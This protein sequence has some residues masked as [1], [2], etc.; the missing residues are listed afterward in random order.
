MPLYQNPYG[1]AAPRSAVSV[2]VPW[3]PFQEGVGYPV[4]NG[5]TGGT[6]DVFVET[7]QLDFTGQV[8]TPTMDYLPSGKAGDPNP[9]N[10]AVPFGVNI[11]AW[12]TQDFLGE[13]FLCY[14]AQTAASRA[15][16]GRPG[17][18][19]SAHMY[20]PAATIID[21]LAAHPEAQP[22]SACGLIVRYSPF[23]NFPDYI[24]ALTSGVRLGIDQGAGYGRVVDATL[25]LPGTGSPA[26]P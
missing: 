9:L 26:I 17:D 16:S 24:T 19:L 6:Q 15:A 11:Q 25:F 13:V 2:M 10:P 8:I 5:T 4:A 21:W 18:I 14:D 20:T 1:A 23:D 7:A 3:L 22:E 12:E